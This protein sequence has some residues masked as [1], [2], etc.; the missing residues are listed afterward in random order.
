VHAHTDIA[1]RPDQRA[2]DWLLRHIQVRAGPMS[3]LYT[4]PDRHLAN[5]LIRMTFWTDDDTLALAKASLIQWFA[6]SEAPQSHNQTLHQNFRE[7]LL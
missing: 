1:E 3:P 4:A 7:P 2:C 6:R 5:A